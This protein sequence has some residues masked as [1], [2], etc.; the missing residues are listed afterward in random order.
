M[1]I[2]SKNLWNSARSQFA[3]GSF[4][5]RGGRLTQF[6]WGA[7]SG[8]GAKSKIKDFGD[9][10]ILPSAV[11]L[12][13]HSRD[14][15]ESHKETFESLQSQAFQGGVAVMACMANTMP[16]L[17]SLER[18]KDFFRRTQKL[19]VRLLPFAAV[20]KNLEGIDATDWDKLL[21]LPIAGL[22]DDGKPILNEDMMRSVLKVTKKFKKL[23]SLHEEDLRISK[24]SVIH[25][26]ASS[27]RLGIDGSPE[28]SEWTMVERDLAL[29]HEVKAHVHFGHLSSAQSVELLRRARKKGVSF[30]AELT[31][32]H[33][34]LTVEDYESL[35]PTLWSKMKVC[36]CIRVST[37]RS[38][39]WRGL[40]EGLLDCLASDHAP[41]TSFE[42]DRPLVEAAHG[43]ISM[44]Y[45]LPLYHEVR[46]RA[47]VSA[48][49]FVRA[50]SQ[51]PAQLLGLQNEVGD[52][53][54]GLKAHFV[55][56][57]PKGEQTIHFDRSRSKNSPFEG[58]SIKG[59][60]V[61]HWIEGGR[62]F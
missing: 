43:M 29:A 13:V 44:Q 60:V 55:V 58:K 40:N 1:R 41:H 62:V 61:E 12:H 10:M 11:D 51:R 54:E 9:L 6:L 23:L 46:S 48:A 56:F 21:K 22:S 31:P 59:R 27:L 49:Q 5:I 15:D 8:K 30:S 2:Y 36:P 32:H 52:L 18:L 47:K 17:D 45:H 53:K 33:A 24:A 35:S 20:T 7:P 34:L 25:L 39:L 16:R 50:L 19:K 28:D 38:S 26:S 4:E 3:E 14:F 42:K 57:D 37:D